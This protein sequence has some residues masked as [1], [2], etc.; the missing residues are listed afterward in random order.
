MAMQ[1]WWNPPANRR[2]AGRRRLR[3]PALLATALAFATTSQAAMGTTVQDELR[4]AQRAGIEIIYSTDLV[5]P[6]LEAPAPGSG[7][8]PLQRAA[9]ALATHGLALRSIGVGKYVVV[10]AEKSPA[11]AMPAMPTRILDEVTVYASRYSIHT[12]QD[13]D[14]KLLTQTDVQTVPGT[15]DD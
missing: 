14:E 6:D 4:A 15:H 10:E 3:L 13:Y 9:A 12:R 5:P 8:T 11:A 2:A 1:S 7:A